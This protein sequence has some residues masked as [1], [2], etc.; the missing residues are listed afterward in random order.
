MK[1]ILLVDDSPIIIKGLK[2]IIG[3]I[4]NLNIAGEAETTYAALDL[5]KQNKPDIVILDINL[6][7]GNGIDIIHDFK[8]LNP[9]TVVIMLTNYSKET[10]RKTSLEHGANYFLDK[11]TDVDKLIEILTELALH[12]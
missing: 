6:R 11:I 5:F 1:N 4:E 8:K 10:F 2:K 7:G 12:N 9:S 3:T